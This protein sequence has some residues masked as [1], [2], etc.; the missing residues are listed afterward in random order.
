MVVGDV[1]LDCYVQGAATKISPEA[2]VPVVRRES[3]TY[4]AGGAANVALNLASLGANVTLI[5]VVGKDDTARILADLPEM[6]HVD[7]HW[8]VGDKP[9][10]C[11]TRFLSRHQQLLRLDDE[12]LPVTHADVNNAIEQHLTNVTHVIFSD[13]AKGAL[14]DIKTLI[15]TCKAHDKTVLVDPKGDDFSRY[16]GADWLKPNFSEFTH[17]VGEAETA[18]QLTQKAN[19]LRTEHAIAHLLITR[20]EDGMSL[21]GQGDEQHFPAKTQEVY[22]VTGA[23]DTVIAL[24]TASLAAGCDANTATDIA[25]IGAGIVVGKLGTASV[26]ANELKSAMDR[27]SLPDFHQKIRSEEDLVTTLNA[28]KQA[29]KRI[30]MTNGC[31][32]ILHAGHVHYLA[33]ARALGDI[34]VVATNTDAS[35]KKLKGD[36]RPVNALDS[37]IAVLA[38]LSAVD[39]VVTFADDTPARLIARC[40]PDVLV[41]GGD[42]DPHAIAGGDVVRENGGEVRALDYLDA[43]STTK[44]IA[45]ITDT[46]ITRAQ[47]AD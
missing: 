9:T 23:G 37:R 42:N 20:S 2:P 3:V 39:F 17:I 25:N 8:L 36:A 4:R 28:L 24:L 19:D 6:Q 1:M 31:F 18:Q 11:K 10:I 27:A 5:G 15:Q 13:Y 35:I 21:F 22:D 7:C 16:H 30:V 45:R 41:K 47:N 26:T 40:L 29:G 33:Q 12:N 34:L 32:D 46:S 38:A 14:A 43:F 44:A